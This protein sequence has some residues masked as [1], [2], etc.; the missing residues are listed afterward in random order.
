MAFYSVEISAVNHYFPRKQTNKR[1]LRERE[2]M[3]KILKYE[4]QFKK[5]FETWNSKRDLLHTCWC[6]KKWG[7]FGNSIKI[8]EATKFSWPFSQETTR[9]RERKRERKSLD[10]FERYE[11]ALVSL[12]P[13]F[14]PNFTST[15]N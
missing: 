11:L 8:R 5:S 4:I 1:K 13:A 14:T 6:S 7:K 15:L 3:Y 12:S 10:L 9:E 2:E